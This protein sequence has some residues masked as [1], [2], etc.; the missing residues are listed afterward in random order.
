MLEGGESI[1]RPW[2]FVL[3]PARFFFTGGSNGVWGV[4][5]SAEAIPTAVGQ[6]RDI[7]Y[8]I[9]PTVG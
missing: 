2:K 3:A 1:H 8:V 5:Y 7:G 4:F 6:I 9:H